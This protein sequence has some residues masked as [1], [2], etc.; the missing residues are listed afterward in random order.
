MQS[1]LNLKVPPH[2]IT[3]TS[4]LCANRSL[5]SLSSSCLVCFFPLEFL[6]SCFPRF[7]LAATRGHLDCLNLILGH[8]VDVTATDATGKWR[9]ME[10]VCFGDYCWPCLRKGRVKGV[11]KVGRQSIQF[12]HPCIG[13]RTSV[14]SALKPA[15]LLFAWTIESFNK[16]SESLCFYNVL[17]FWTLLLQIPNSNSLVWWKMIP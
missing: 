7:H 8:N 10:A 16:P 14:T 3:S 11:K 13:I 4:L 2:S 1:P 6:C 17:L 9:P 15:D 5:P 12:V